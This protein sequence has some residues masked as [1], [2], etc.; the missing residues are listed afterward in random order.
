MVSLL[1]DAV[2]VESLT[3]LSRFRTDFYDCLT[4]RANALFELADAVLCTDEPVRSLV[5]LA[6]APSTAGATAPSTL[7]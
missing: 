4:A 6:L 2:R 1:H 5:D 3:V 7:A